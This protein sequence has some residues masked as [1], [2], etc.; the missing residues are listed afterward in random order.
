MATATLHY[1]HDPFCGWCYGAAPLVAAC[2]PARLASAAASNGEAMC[3]PM[4][5]ASPR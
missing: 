2:S 4:T 3:C 5:A 1:F